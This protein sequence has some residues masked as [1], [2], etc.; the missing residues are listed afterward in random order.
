[1]NDNDLDKLMQDTEEAM[2]KAVEAISKEM[3]SI[4]TG[5]ASVS[6]LD[7]IKVE[8]Y[9]TSTPINQ[10]ATVSAP[11][12]K[13]LMIQPW[14]KS[15]IP[16]IEKAIYGSDLGLTP[17][18]DGK[19]IRL[20]VPSLTEERRKELTKLVGR[21]AEEGKIS[22]RRTRSDTNKILKDMEKEKE[23]SEDDRIRYENE[24]Q[25]LTDK[26]CGEI[27]ILLER[28]KEELMKE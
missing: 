8:C 10:V 3:A 25:K 18:N 2:Q 16:N 22:I 9:G 27:D 26:Y 6:L 4:R 5:I 13:L 19:V 17:V 12:P 24:V 7:N 20:K 28:K 21:L 1:V 11:E 23:I 15:I 14:D